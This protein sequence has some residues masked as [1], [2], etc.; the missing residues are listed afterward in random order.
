MMP[1]DHEVDHLYGGDDRDVPDYAMPWG[2][3]D[4]K[5]DRYDEGGGY[6]LETALLLVV[7]TWTNL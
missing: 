3:L 6:E 7:G 4:P 2:T 5:R 1:Q